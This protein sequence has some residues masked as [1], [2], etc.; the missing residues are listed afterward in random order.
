MRRS[1]IFTY[2]NRVGKA[3]DIRRKLLITLL[4]L[5]IYRLASHV[6]VPGANRDVIVGILE[7]G[8]AAGALVG[9]MDMLAGG[10]VSNFS[11]MAMGVYPYITSQIILQLLVPIIPSWKARMEDDQREG[12]RWME[13]WTVILAIPMAALQAVGQINLFTAFAG[14][15]VIDNFGLANP[16]SSAAILIGMNSRNH[17]RNLAG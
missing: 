9:I 4:I 14:A 15:P 11:I 3:H 7:G 2:I 13:R 17:V 16:L 8:G 6:P 12:R 1:A 5:A 10:T